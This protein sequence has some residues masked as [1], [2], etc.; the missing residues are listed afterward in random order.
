[1]QPCM[2][3]QISELLHLFNRHFA[4]QNNIGFN[5]DI[6]LLRTGKTFSFLKKM[7]QR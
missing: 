4:D 7:N 2:Q 1:M 5:N 3:I 6:A